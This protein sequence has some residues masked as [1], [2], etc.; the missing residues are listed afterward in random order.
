MSNQNS[1]SLHE[2]RQ[3]TGKKGIPYKIMQFGDSGDFVT[4]KRSKTL[5]KLGLRTKQHFTCSG[6][7]STNDQIRWSAKSSTVDPSLSRR[8]YCTCIKDV[9][10]I[11]YIISHDI[12]M[13]LISSKRINIRIVDSKFNIWWCTPPNS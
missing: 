8:C 7:H 4:M 9:P 13:L 6:F 5:Q 2:T 11:E 3:K 12:P 10:S 1:G